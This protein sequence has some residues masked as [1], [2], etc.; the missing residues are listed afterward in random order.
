MALSCVGLVPAVL[1]CGDDVMW[2]EARIVIERP[3]ATAC[4]LD[5]AADLTVHALG[6][7]PASGSNVAR[8]NP[9]DGSFAIDRFPTDTRVLRFEVGSPEVEAGAALEL[10]TDRASQ[11]ALL[12]PVERSCP[13]PDFEAR[14]RLGA[15]IA[16][17]PNGSLLI[18]GGRN[19]DFGD[20]S[21]GAA[22]ST[23]FVL[24]AG[25][26][27]VEQVDGG[28]FL[29]RSGASATLLGDKVWVIGGGAHDRGPAHETFE[30]FDVPLGRFSVSAGSELVHGPRRDHAAIALADGS[31]VLVVGGVSELGVAP[32][33]S[34]E[35]VGAAGAE[36]AGE[37]SIGR[38][39]PSL[40]RL[41]DGRVLIVGGRDQADQAVTLVEVFDPRTSEISRTEVTFDPA[42]HAA[43]ATLIGDRV[44]WIG[45]DGAA[46]RVSLVQATAAGE[47][48]IRNLASLPALARLSAV[49]LSDG[50][51]LVVGQRRLSDLAEA[52]RVD[53][54]SATVTEWPASRVAS[55]LHPLSDGTIAELDATGLSLR[56]DRIVTPFDN[57][58]ATLIAGDRELSVDVAAHWSRSSGAL[59]AQTDNARLDIA[60]LSFGAFT[61]TL[62]ATVV[63]NGELT[64]NLSE[65]S[66]TTTITVTESTVRVG[67]C[68]ATRGDSTE[69]VTVERRGD[70]LTLRSGDAT[71]DCATT[72]PAHV[73][74]SLTASTGCTVGPLKVAR[75]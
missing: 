67:D 39:Q 34:A 21:E 64:L 53:V 66:A 41:S 12:L 60:G 30:T 6:D 13:S 33:S 20:Q 44:A 32:L 23:A 62:D 63:A 1:G 58:P 59:V 65:T 71:T 15:A 4:R 40:H 74:L 22:T 70:T 51:L 28:M 16:A 2:A 26:E 45:C 10:R 61:L 36:D 9:E 48:A 49:G 73:S 42:E 55:S 11:T 8:L 38:T 35:L 75:R 14:A 57:L 72:L 25:R 43:S 47:R 52:W 7:F 69:P 68:S 56:R 37:L 18:A 24:P 54:G 31:G 17:L 3:M 27:L 46:C 29:R 5:P 19:D 50:A